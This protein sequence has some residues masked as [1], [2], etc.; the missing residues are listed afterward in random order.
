MGWQGVW[1]RGG[2]RATTCRA[3]PSLDFPPAAWRAGGTCVSP[4]HNQAAQRLAFHSHTHHHFRTP[5]RP[6]AVTVAA[7]GDLAA[8]PPRPSPPPSSSSSGDRPPLRDGPSG[9]GRGG[10]GRG[11]GGGGRYAP[12]G[13]PGG[14]GGGGRGGGRYGDSRTAGAGRGGPGGP[15]TGGGRFGQNAGGGRY[16]QAAG[17]G[18]GTGGRFTPG[19]GTGGRFAPGGGRGSYTPRPPGA[20]P[21]TPSSST[22]PPRREYAPTD[23][24]GSVFDDGGPTRYNRGRRGDRSTPSPYGGLIVNEAI[25]ADE[26]RLLGVDK[27]M[28]GVMRLSD[29]LE[30][31]AEEGV[32]VVLISPDA[33]PPVARLVSASKYRFEQVRAAKDASKKQ[34]ESRRDMK[35]LKMRINTDV[36]DYQVRLRAAAKF[37]AKGDTVKLSVQFR[38]REMERKADAVTMFDK[39]VEDVAK[40]GGFD[41]VVQSPPAM[42]GRSMT[43]I[44]GPKNDV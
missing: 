9:G 18:R 43:M 5:Q 31:A 37:I 12:G 14:P 30:L 26:V 27:A 16:G 6:L 13:G 10:P 24:A 3:A 38:G 34:R 25:Q 36:H 35:E 11:P 29:A 33:A 32:D 20:G 23:S 17:G 22:A 28:L 40:E 8:P 42:A 15:G 44:M 1:R 21:Y 19:G 2:A 4:P 39:F 7:S 41:V